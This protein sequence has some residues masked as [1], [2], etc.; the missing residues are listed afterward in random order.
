M[1]DIITRID[2]SQIEIEIIVIWKFN[3]KN[4]AHRFTDVRE[5]RKWHTAPAVQSPS[6]SLLLSKK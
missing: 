4:E 1:R 2:N 5:I 3:F 6:H